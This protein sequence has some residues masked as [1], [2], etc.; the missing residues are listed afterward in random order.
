[1]PGP[2]PGAGQL[3]VQAPAEPERG[4]ARNRTQVLIDF[5]PNV[6]LNKAYISAA[7]EDTAETERLVRTWFRGAV[8]DLAQRLN[9]RHHACRA[10]GMAAAAA[11]AVECLRSAFEEPSWAH[12]FIEPFLPYYDSIRNHSQ[13]V[14]FLAELPRG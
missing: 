12:P 13:Y 10:L 11:A 6:H 5:E 2:S 3:P 8:R 14:E 9:L 4:L 1:M 7:Q